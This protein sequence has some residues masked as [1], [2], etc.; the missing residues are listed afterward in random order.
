M[1]IS[2]FDKFSIC[3]KSNFVF[4]KWLK[5]VVTVIT[6]VENNYAV[7]EFKYTKSKSFSI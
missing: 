3:D 7:T 6:V 1:F 2:E 5:I 4:F